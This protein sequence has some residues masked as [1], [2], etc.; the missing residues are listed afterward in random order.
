MTIK[1]G[2]F[3]LFI[4]ILLV[5][6]LLLPSLSLESSNSILLHFTFLLNGTII[7]L[8]LVIEAG[9]L[10]YSCRT[11]HWVFFLFFFFLSPY[12]QFLFK[13]WP[14]NYSPTVP[15]MIRANLLIMLWST[16]FHLTRKVQFSKGGDI[17]FD[18][19][20][21]EMHIKHPELF[22]FSES[23]DDNPSK[24]R[25]TLFLFISFVLVLYLVS[26]V[27]L[28]T[29][30]SS[31]SGGYSAYQSS[32]S[33]ESSLISNTVRNTISFTAFLNAYRFQK[34]R[35]NLSLLIIS[36]ALLMIGCSPFGLPRFQVAAIYLTIIMLLLPK[37]RYSLLCIIGF[38][39]VFMFVFPL[40]GAF[41]YTEVG[42][43]DFKTLL[44][45][46]I[47]NFQDE[48][49]TA[50]YDAYTIILKTFDYVAENSYTYGRQLICAILFFIPR[51]VWPSK[52]VSTGALLQAASGAHSSAYNV[53]SSLIVE[54]MIDFGIFG[55]ILYCFLF[56]LI[57]N[58]IDAKLAMPDRY[59]KA[60]TIIQV[61]MPPLLFF[62]LRGS[63][64]SVW[65]FIASYLVVGFAMIKLR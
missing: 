15:R 13:Q 60:T 17:F 1:R 40:I 2:Q 61:L 42:N 64:L 54:G 37:W 46:T 49:L 24:A 5:V 20:S 35:D 51:T 7:I 38:I 59:S 50:N 45:R 3:A 63:L 58:R 33:A 25:L 22:V 32:S 43:I 39:V 27:G 19:T 55:V 31:R 28:I 36:F 8:F 48:Y 18:A 29:L 21:S 62:L 4:V 11:L 56:S 26:R 44:I 6:L 12:L 57:C 10:P 23:S 47:N 34:K 65:P 14:L 16:L 9:T 53:S 30:V 52:S 41:R